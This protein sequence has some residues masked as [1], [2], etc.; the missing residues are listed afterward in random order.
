MTAT[1]ETRFLLEGEAAYQAAKRFNPVSEQVAKDALAARAFHLERGDTENARDAH[2]QFHFTI[3]EA[4]SNPWLIR[5]IMPLWRNAERYR[6]ESMRR[7]ELAAQRAR[8]H[9]SILAAVVAGDA[10][11]ARDR[12][13]EHLRSSMQLALNM[14]APEAADA[15]K[16]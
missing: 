5:S 15:T 14:F 2:E 10:Q 9:E 12:T 1:Y 4:A 13:V 11:A 16:P 3:Y 8:E 7:P 6:L